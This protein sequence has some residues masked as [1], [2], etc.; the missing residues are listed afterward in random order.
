M[1]AI[2][3]RG[4]P[5]LDSIHARTH[6]NRSCRETDV[7]KP[8]HADRRCLIENC[9]RGCTDREEEDVYVTRA[10]IVRGCS[11][12]RGG[13]GYIYVLKSK[14]LLHRI[15]SAILVKLFSSVVSFK[16]SL[17]CCCVIDSEHLQ[18][19]AYKKERV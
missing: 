8:S 11:K 13:G 18:V 19:L 14:S 7:V 5:P 15:L 6:I 2:S 17:F 4:F 9:W 12:K 10:F 1:G 3:G 16:P